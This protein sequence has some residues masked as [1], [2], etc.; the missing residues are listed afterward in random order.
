MKCTHSVIPTGLYVYIC[1]IPCL[2]GGTEYIRGGH[3]KACTASHQS[4]YTTPPH[5]PVPP[6]PPHSSLTPPNPRPL[7]DNAIICI[8]TD[9]QHHQHNHHHHHHHHHHYH[10]TNKTTTNT[11]ITITTSTTIATTITNITNTITT[12]IIIITTWSIT[13]EITIIRA[14]VT[15]GFI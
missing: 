15:C 10:T 4:H 11:I 1:H 14:G 8:P 5:S 9:H 7:P 13:K 6:P 2:D 12:T 3:F